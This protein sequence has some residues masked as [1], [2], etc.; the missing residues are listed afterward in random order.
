MIFVDRV[1]FNCLF[2]LSEQLLLAH[3]DER[4]SFCFRL[5]RIRLV[6][7]WMCV[8]VSFF[9][10]YPY[11]MAAGSLES[12]GNGNGGEEVVERR[13]AAASARCNWAEL[14]CWLRLLLRLSPRSGRR[15]RRR[16]RRNWMNSI[17]SDE[18]K[19]AARAAP[20]T[21]NASRQGYIYT[22][23]RR[24]KEKKNRRTQFVL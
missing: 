16:L 11:E 9:F 13:A 18:S 1:L 6:C 23:S 5:V 21:R 10:V 12:R 19:I 24:L 15:R 7:V 4:E 14:C 2:V 20:R 3:T 8:C 22:R 17:H